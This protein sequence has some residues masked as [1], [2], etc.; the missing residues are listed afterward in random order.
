MISLRSLGVKT[1]NEAAAQFNHSI[2]RMGASRLA[3]FQFMSPWRL[4]PAADSARSA[5]NICPMFLMEAACKVLILTGI[6][7]LF[8]CSNKSSSR[9]T[10]A[11]AKRC[12]QCRHLVGHQGRDSHNR[13]SDP[14]RYGAVGNEGRGGCRTGGHSNDSLYS[15]KALES[16]PP[17]KQAIGDPFRT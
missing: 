3:Q 16:G 10:V 9:V 17:G 15:R 4:A 5:H 11:S 6:T 2:Q 7:L 13:R 12:P 1:Q 14:T 8:G